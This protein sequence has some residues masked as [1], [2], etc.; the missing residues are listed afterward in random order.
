MVQAILSITVIIVATT[1]SVWAM[2]RR[3]RSLAAFTL[4]AALL[5]TA[6]LEASTLFSLSRPDLFGYWERWSLFAEG[7]MPGVW[8]LASIT[9][10][11][12]ARLVDLRLSQKVLLF[13]SLLFLVP[14]LRSPVA[15]FYYSPDFPVEQVLFLG[16]VGFPFYISVM[17]FLVAALVNLETTLANATPGELWKLKFAT[18]GIGTIL[19]S[20][21][22][23]YSQALL[24]RTINLHF[25]PVRSFFLILGVGMLTYGRLRK[26]DG[27]KIRVS[28]QVAFK[29]VVLIAVGGYLVLIGLL[30]EGMRYFG[31]EFQRSVVIGFIVLSGIALL[32][33]FLSGRV[34]REIKVFLH[35]NFYQ[36]KYDYRVQWLQFTERLAN[37]QSEADLQQVILSAYC[38]TFGIQSAALYL[39]DAERRLFVNTAVYEMGALT[40]TFGPDD[41]LV[42]YIDGRGW[43]FRHTDSFL[44][45]STETRA[46]MEKCHV[47]FVVPLLSGEQLEGFIVLGR[48]VNPHETIIYEDFDL[49]KTIARQA[50]F[51]LRNQRLSDQ[52]TRVREMEA[53]GNIATFVIHDVKNYVAGLSLMVDNAR[54][55][56]D[57]PEFQQDMLGSLDNTVKKM[58]GLIARLKNLGEKELLNLQP[59]DLLAVVNRAVSFLPAGRVTVNGERLVV[60]VDAEEMQKVI[61]NLLLNAVE[62]SPADAPVSVEVGLAGTPFVRV[63]DQGIGM[64]AEYIRRELFKPF[65][66]TKKKGL[67]IGLYQSRQIVEAHGG[68]L[69]VQ[70]EVGK[71]TLFTIVLK[72]GAGESEPVNL[73]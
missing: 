54:H 41:A 23:Y 60:P 48:Q 20:Y 12:E 57:N 11:R 69:E 38:D 1:F 39:L 42:R 16:P 15:G 33:L 64:S 10:A 63:I 68:R 36:S 4:S 13:L 45:L 72:H 17:I 25:L 2:L 3:E 43:V 29:S 27:V 65:A 7:L 56:I 32:L 71:G 5:V 19:A 70:S 30:G 34:R 61:L 49:M 31:A 53:I 6:L 47:S 18:L 26:G 40:E 8:L 35:K 55:Y 62:A 37:R 51:A 22:L 44:E 46:F 52:L 50:S 67:G 24:F 58:Q 59:I 9:H 73:K 66:T 14:V 28:R 21:A